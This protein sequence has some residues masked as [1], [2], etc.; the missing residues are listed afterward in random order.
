MPA[1]LLLSALAAA[2]V[3]AGTPEATTEPAGELPPALTAMIDTALASG[4][5]TE[6]EAVIRIAKRALPQSA[7]AIDRRVAKW[8]TGSKVPSVVQAAISPP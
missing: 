2:T 1:C 8:R 5:E 3:V 6:A 7:D 4:D